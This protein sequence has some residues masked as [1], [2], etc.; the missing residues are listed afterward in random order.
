MADSKQQF[1]YSKNKQPSTNL[2]GPFEAK[3][4]PKAPSAL[5]ARL[6]RLLN[7]NRILREIRRIPLVLVGLLALAVLGVSLLFFARPRQTHE[8]DDLGQGVLSVSGLRGHLVTRWN[9]KAQYQLHLEPLDYPDNPGFALVAGNPHQPYS[10]NIRLLDSSGFSLCD[11]QILF[12]FDPARAVAPV[13][14]PPATHRRKPAEAAAELAALQ[15]AQQAQLQNA[16]AQEQQRERGQ[17]IFQNQYGDDGKVVG[18]NAQGTLPCSVDA[19]RHFYYWDFTSNFPTRDEQQA[20]LDSKAAAAAAQKLAQQQAARHHGAVRLP[21][22]G[23]YVAGDETVTSYDP[24]RR[25]LIAGPGKGFFITTG[26]GQAIA[27]SWA[28]KNELVHYRCDQ[29]A[30]CTLTSAGGLTAIRAK[31]N[32]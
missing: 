21:M 1:P 29:H 3:E 12:P 19:Y 8:S 5:S 15:S 16:Q 28:A 27:A 2:Y 20:M 18:L 6:T 11:K 22:P 14:L 32:E 7:E 24:S 9:G 4:E 23:F 25:L 26:S 31:L 10:I 30:L 17:D 13:E